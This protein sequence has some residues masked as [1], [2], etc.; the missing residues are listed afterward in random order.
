M[1]E[2]V[3]VRIDGEVIAAA[4]GQSIL[5]VALCIVRLCVMSGGWF[6]AS[7]LWQL[8]PATAAKRTPYAQL[9]QVRWTAA[10]AG[11]RLLWNIHPRR[12]LK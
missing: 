9:F 10:N 8:C 11:K 4:A 7:T 12:G 3:K 5:Q 6:D 2:K 1:T